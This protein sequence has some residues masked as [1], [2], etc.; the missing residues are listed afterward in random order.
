MLNKLEAETGVNV[1]VSFSAHDVNS[2]TAASF[3]QGKRVTVTP[4]TTSQIRTLYASLGFDLADSIYNKYSQSTAGLSYAFDIGESMRVIVLDASYYEYENGYT[5]VS[6]KLT[7]DLKKWLSTELQ[8]ADITDRTAVAMC[9]WSISGSSLFGNDGFMTD[10]DIA[11]NYFADAGL[12]YVFTSGA[13]K[14]NISAVISDNGNIVY[15]V[16]SASIVSFPNT[17]RVCS[18]NGEKAQ[19]DI[20]DADETKNIVSRDGTEYAKPYRET[21]SLRLQYA[22]Y[23]LARYCADVI[24]NYVTSILIPGVKLNGTLELHKGAVRCFSHRLHK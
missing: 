15:D 22:D 6:G 5:R 1:A 10:A 4:A 23:D 21:A 18:F 20:V 17:Y 11:A 2:T 13:D 7:T 16:Q 24:K 19:F 3:A 12:N 9:P 8:Y 14:N